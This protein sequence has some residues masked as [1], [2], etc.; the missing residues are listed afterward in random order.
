MSCI[1]GSLGVKGPFIKNRS[2]AALPPPSLL[3]TEIL[4]GRILKKKKKKSGLIA[5]VSRNFGEKGFDGM[6]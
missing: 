2:L 3:C 5:R 1:L 6:K 4:F